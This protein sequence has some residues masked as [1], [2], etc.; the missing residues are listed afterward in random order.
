MKILIMDHTRAD[1]RDFIEKGMT[2]AIKFGAPK[3]VYLNLLL[4]KI[5]HLFWLEN[6]NNSNQISDVYKKNRNLERPFRGVSDHSRVHF[7]RLSDFDQ[8]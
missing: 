5:K 2:S 3:S 8:R 7:K 6:P 1:P 4:A